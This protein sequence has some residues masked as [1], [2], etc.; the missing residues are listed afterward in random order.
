MHSADLADA[1]ADSAAT[2][3]NHLSGL[4]AGLL[5]RTPGAVDALLG[6]NDGLKLAFT[7]Q[8]LDKADAMAATVSGLVS[9]A[10]TPF[11]DSSGNVRQIV[12]EHDDGHVFVM[13]AGT[14]SG[15][16][17]ATVLAVLTTPAADPGQVGHEM[18]TLI[19]GLDEH[20]VTRARR[21]T[22]G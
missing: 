21:N 20:L 11:Q 14:M 5:A 16:G 13:S 7:S 3:R 6:T 17:L 4:L 1:A 10:R 15:D 8:S 18:A 19:T 22:F 9:L 2:A 12:I